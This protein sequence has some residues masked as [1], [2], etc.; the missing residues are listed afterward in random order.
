MLLIFPKSFH[1]EL[2]KPD[3]GVP[4]SVL[5]YINSNI[6]VPMINVTYK[7]MNAAQRL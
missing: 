2:S 1:A 6:A 3:S 7:C 5:S 4:T